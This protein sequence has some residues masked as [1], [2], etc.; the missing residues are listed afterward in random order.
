MNKRS[1]AL[2][3]IA[4]NVLLSCGKIVAGYIAHS[5][6]I[7][8]DG[9][10]SVTDVFSSIIGY[11]G[12][13]AS[14]KPVDDRHPYGHYKL[15][16]LSSVAITVILMATGIGV[17]LS[18]YAAY[19]APRQASLDTLPVI[20]ML[21][22]IA[23]NLA[24]SRLKLHYGRKEHSLTLLAD[25]SNDAADVLA[26]A[27]VLLGVWLSRYWAYADSLLAFLI[28]GYIIFKASSLGRDALDSL[29]DSS[30][31]DEV[32]DIIRSV[33]T[34]AH[35]PI[36]TLRTQRKG[37]AITAN[38]EIDLPSGLTVDEA[39]RISDNLREK[40][41]QAVPG[42]VYVALQIRSHDAVV[43]FYKPVIGRGFGWHAERKTQRTASDSSDRGPGG[44]CV[45]PE[46]G[47]SVTH[48]KGVSCSALSCPR[49]GAKLQRRQGAG[50]D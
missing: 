24:T 47:Y 2:L 30:A 16:V 22:S 3:S 12:I 17:S 43:D 23:I 41:M 10:H 5:A 1:V 13:N 39:V 48:E 29:L 27:A 33:A 26:S 35:V 8:A 28:G 19:L 6:A 40:S 49:C 9:V 14:L 15:E 18:A 4:A 50:T 21:L 45:C 36:A 34:E 31:G 44:F 11:V 37:S 42:L 25:G 38:L 7:T 32:E 46:C 20:V